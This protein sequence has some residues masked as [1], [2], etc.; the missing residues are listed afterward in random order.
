MENVSQTEE[1]EQRLRGMRIWKME[2][3]AGRR[4]RAEEESGEASWKGPSRETP[5]S[6]WKYKLYPKD[7]S[8]G[9]DTG[10]EKKFTMEFLKVFCWNISQMQ[11][12][13]EVEMLTGQSFSIST[14]WFF[15][16]FI[17]LF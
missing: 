16:R 12:E 6:G 4:D 2:A 5:S 13:V 11:M 14:D 9:V 8:K 7:H 10:R 3:E 1:Y 17:C 15:Y